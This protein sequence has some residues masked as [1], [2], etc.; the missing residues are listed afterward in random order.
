MDTLQRMPF[1]A[2][3][4]VFARLEQIVDIAALTKEEREKYDESIKVYRDQLA[5]M[6]FE[7]QKGFQ[8]GKKVGF[9]DGMEQGMEKGMKKGMEKGMEKGER[10]KQ[11]DIARRMKMKGYPIKEIAGLTGLSAEEVVDL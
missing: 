5:I 4:S 7:K 2:R 11:E 9:A 6:E 8:Q 1:K 3:K 10:K